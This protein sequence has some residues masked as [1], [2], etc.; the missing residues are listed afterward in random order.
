MHDARCQ[1]AFNYSSLLLTRKLRESF[2]GK[3][4]SKLVKSWRAR[5][6]TRKTITCTASLKVSY[7]AEYRRAALYERSRSIIE[8]YLMTV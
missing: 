5:A 1:K 2:A 3:Q 8:A 4:T 7:L 6:R